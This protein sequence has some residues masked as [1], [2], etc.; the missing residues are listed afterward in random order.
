LNAAEATAWIQQRALGELGRDLDTY[1]DDELQEVLADCWLEWQA[2]YGT[3]NPNG[4]DSMS[5]KLNGV[6]HEDAATTPA[7]RVGRL[8]RKADL[9]SDASK[10]DLVERIGDDLWKLGSKT[11]TTEELDAELERQ[12]ETYEAD[13]QLR[14][15]LGL[16]D[17]RREGDALHKQAIELLHSRGIH[18]PT[19]A[20]L[21]DVYEELGAP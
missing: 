7:E 2:M 20:D 21:L 5:Y 19:S 12:G 18:Q 17:E 4:G 13:A 11:L 3:H 1:S 6:Q 8:E 16:N 15:D 10:D 14:R 9:R